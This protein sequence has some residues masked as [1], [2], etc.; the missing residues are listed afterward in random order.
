MAE[1][2]EMHQ[3]AALVQC[4]ADGL[5][6]FVGSQPLEL[7]SFL[8]ETSLPVHRTQNIEA[9]FL[10]YDKVVG[11][12]TGSRMHAAGAGVQSY[13]LAQNDHGFPIDQRMGAGYIFQLGTKPVVEDL[14]LVSDLCLFEEE[15]D[16]LG[17]DQPFLTAN[18]D[19]RV[20]EIGMDADGQIGR[21]SPGCG[22]PNHDI[23]VFRQ[24]ALAVSDLK[25]N[26]DGSGF[27]IRIFDLSLGQS[28]LAMRAPIYRFQALVYIALL[29]HFGKSAD[30]GS[31]EIRIQSEIRIIPI[32]RHTETTELLF[33]SFHITESELLA[34]IAEHQFIGITAIQAQ[35]VD[36]LGLDRQTVGV[37]ARHVRSVKTAH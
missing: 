10:A 33:L 9:V 3:S 11:A 27:H 30:L 17:S 12:V 13:V 20:I 31:F 26:V 21:D 18:G 34:A 35:S 7:E 37:P 5:V 32:A 24:N 19:E 28:G 6:A 22:G 15:I 8:S 16:H 25:L 1:H 2:S 23:S 4:F 36:S 14:I 29:G